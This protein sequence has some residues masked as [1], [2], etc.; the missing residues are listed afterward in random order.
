MSSKGISRRDT[1]PLPPASI[2]A[3]QR[4]EA[5]TTRSTKANFMQRSELPGPPR[6]LADG[7]SPVRQHGTLPA[8]RRATPAA[9]DTASASLQLQRKV[10]DAFLS[11]AHGEPLLPHA[12]SNL[13]EASRKAAIGYIALKALM[14]STR[15]P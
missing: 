10:T 6:P 5:A 4:A 9:A 14:G 1:P 3:E 12:E 7:A 8:S 11:G 2:A 15:L 13:D